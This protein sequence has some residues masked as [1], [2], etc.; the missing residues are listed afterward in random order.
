MSIAAWCIPLLL[1][2]QSLLSQPVQLVTN[3]A[4]KEPNFTAIQFVS[5]TNGYAMTQHEVYQTTDGGQH[6]KPILATSKA[7]DFLKAPNTSDLFVVT[8]HELLISTDQ[9]SLFHHFPLPK[10]VNQNFTWQSFHFVNQQFGWYFEANYQSQPV[11][12]IT[13][14]GGKTWTR[15]SLPQNTIGLGFSDPNHGFAFAASPKGSGTFYQVSDQG[16]KYAITMN[17]HSTSM[18]Y[19]Q[20]ATFNVLSDHLA[21]LQILGQA[22]MSQSSS[23]LFKTIN[24]RTWQ[25]IL[26]VSTAGGGPAPGITARNIPVGPGYDAGPFSVIDHNHLFVIGGMEATGMG[27]V[28]LAT[29][30]NGGHTWKTY[31]PIEGANGIASS[32]EDLSFV[33]AKDGWLLLGAGYHPELLRTTDGGQ[34]WQRCGSYANWPTIDMQLFNRTQ[35][36]GLGVVGDSNAIIKTIDGTKSWKIIGQL[37][38]KKDLP[39]V[40]TNGS[41]IAMITPSQGYAIGGDRNLYETEN[42]GTQWYALSSPAPGHLLGITYSSAKHTLY[43]ITDKE[44]IYASSNEGKAWS[45][46][47]TTSTWLQN[48]THRSS[49]PSVIAQWSTNQYGNILLANAGQTGQLAYV[50][51]PDSTGIFVSHHGQ[52]TF[53]LL[54]FPKNA[55]LSIDKVQFLTQKIGYLITFTN[56]LY[57][58]EDGG[59]V[60]REISPRYSN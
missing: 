59:L 48:M 58:T 31:L 30:T 14:N 21:Y 18:G 13:M 3:A 46:P 34:S 25:P 45:K 24:G 53:T 4:P 33:N 15:L 32:Q 27:E 44:Q 54:A 22:G 40:G 38:V 6:F 56:D 8:G 50:N 16:K 52:D 60:W 2:T 36:I 57:I 37:P 17:V 47:I 11:C 1:S 10:F 9:G 20:S 26:G 5:P 43:L 29:S 51:S 42:G 28:A 19:A 7:I 39:Y 49:F 35:G 12:G 55:L 41:M 23:S